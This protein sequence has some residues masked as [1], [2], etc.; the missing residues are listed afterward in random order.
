M[1]RLLTALFILCLS[2][3]YTACDNSAPSLSDAEPVRSDQAAPSALEKGN[4]VSISN[5]NLVFS[6]NAYAT[7]S[8]TAPDEWTGNPYNDSVDP[9]D[10]HFVYFILLKEGYD[11]NYSTSSGYAWPPSSNSAVQNGPDDYLKQAFW[12]GDYFIG[13]SYYGAGDVLYP[14]LLNGSNIYY[15]G[16]CPIS[17]SA[18]QYSASISMPLQ[19]SSNYTGSG[20]IGTCT[21]V[22][23]TTS[24]YANGSGNIEQNGIDDGTYEV[25][26]VNEFQSKEGISM[27]S[28]GASP[29]SFARFEI[30]NGQ[31]IVDPCSPPQSSVQLLIYGH[32]GDHAELDWNDAQCADE[33]KVYRRLPNSLRPTFAYDLAFW[34]SAGVIVGV[35]VYSVV[36]VL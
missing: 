36:K 10:T 13:D 26:M 11:N 5:G 23:F 14:G 3:L 9:E 32:T 28:A 8:G 35:G 6:G 20:S 34:I 30:E 21:F 15:G 4:V 22:P 31:I 17:L 7:G 27:I 18:G 1:N 19:G 12:N 33:Y 25:F 2:L 24:T 16:E 29:M